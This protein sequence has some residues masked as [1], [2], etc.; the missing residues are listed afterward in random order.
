MTNSEE[1][2]DRAH[3][4]FMGIYSINTW[5]NHSSHQLQPALLQRN[6]K[7]TIYYFQTWDATYTTCLWN[8]TY[9]TIDKHL[10]LYVLDL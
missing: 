5:Y 9:I 2:N 10:T 6:N 1:P 8:A 3:E 4:L 7:Q